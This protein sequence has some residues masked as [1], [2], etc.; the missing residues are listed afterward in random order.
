[1]KINR[2]RKRAIEKARKELEDLENFK[3]HLAMI[4]ASYT[5][6]GE[7]GAHHGKLTVD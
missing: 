7:D 5:G 4:G 3:E 2:R 1:M 6:K